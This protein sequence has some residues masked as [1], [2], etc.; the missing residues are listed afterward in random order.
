MGGIASRRARVLAVV[1]ISQLVGLALLLVLLR[2]F[3]AAFPTS[4]DFMFGALAGVTGSAGI[5]FLSRGLSR[6]RVSVV[7]PITA[8]IAAVAPVIFGP[9]AGERPSLIALVGVV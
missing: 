3:P 5:A 6:G 8:V 2:V 7:S 4:R 1:V 9:T